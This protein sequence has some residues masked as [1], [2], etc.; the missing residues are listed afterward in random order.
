MSPET[1]INMGFLIGGAI[2]A[3]FGAANAMRERIAKLEAKLDAVQDSS[4][5]AFD[6]AFAH[7]QNAHSRIDS[8][9]DK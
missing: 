4:R 7:A 9:L 1:I 2:A 5:G 8:V 3:Y 6:R